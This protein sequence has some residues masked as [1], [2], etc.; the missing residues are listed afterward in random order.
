MDRRIAAALAALFIFIVTSAAPAQAQE[1]GVGTAVEVRVSQVFVYLPEVSVY[2]LFRDAN[3]AAVAI[4]GVEKLTVKV[5]G[6]IC[7]ITRLDD[8]YE[9]PEPTAYSIA[10]D[11]SRTVSGA[12]IL[13]AMQDLAQFIDYISPEDVVSISTF[14][15]DY[16]LLT[17]FTNDKAVLRDILTGIY[18]TDNNTLFYDGLSRVLDM[19][20]QPDSGVPPRR[21]VLVITDGKDEGSALTLEDLLAK[22]NLIGIPIYSIGYTK[23]SPKYLNNLKRLSELSVGRF[24]PGGMGEVNPF[25]LVAGELASQYRILA[26]T[27]SPADGRKHVVQVLYDSSG[28]VVSGERG[29]AFYYEN[30]EIRDA[31]KRQRLILGVSVGVALAIILLVLIVRLKRKT[32]EPEPAPAADEAVPLV[33]DETEVAQEMNFVGAETEN[34]YL[35]EE[36][37]GGFLAGAAFEPNAEFVVI[38]GPTKGDRFQAYISEEGVTIGGEGCGVSIPGQGLNSPHCAVFF[39][40]GIFLLKNLSGEDEVLQNGIP[41]ASRKVLEN[42]DSIEMG[43]LALRFKSFVLVE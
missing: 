11:I 29:V 33:Q 24:V 18:P 28:R 26:E 1:E 9:Y 34:G 13:K 38:S 37:E 43:G 19:N 17:P 3:G 8:L 15:D 39:Q 32:V 42:S 21:V 36:T 10:V 40:D 6:E 5:D 4:E 30:V 22:T 14:G 2:G 27:G 12:P 16:R 35:T 41:V 25:A 20:K 23:I 7:P 31:E